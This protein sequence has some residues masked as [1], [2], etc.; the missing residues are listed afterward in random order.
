MKFIKIENQSSGL[1]EPM[2]LNLDTI[3]KICIEKNTVICNFDYVE[4]K[5]SLIYAYMNNGEKICLKGCR[6][7]DEAL[8]AL[9]EISKKLNS[10]GVE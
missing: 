10:A 3:N 9:D 4:V 1:L 8:K 7:Y 5:N 2:L 6:E